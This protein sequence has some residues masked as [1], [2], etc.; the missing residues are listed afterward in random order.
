MDLNAVLKKPS[1]ERPLTDRLFGVFG[2]VPQTRQSHEPKKPNE[3]NKRDQP[4]LLATRQAAI[5][6]YP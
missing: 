2:F 6:P 4:D 5:H 3:P 1:D